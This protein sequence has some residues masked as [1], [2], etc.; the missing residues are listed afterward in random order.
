[1]FGVTCLLAVPAFPLSSPRL[2]ATWLHLQ[3]LLCSAPGWK[4]LG[5][6]DCSERQWRLI[7]EELGPVFRICL[8]LFPWDSLFCRCL[9]SAWGPNYLAIPPSLASPGTAPGS[10]P[11][12][13]WVLLPSASFVHLACPTLVPALLPP[14][15]PSF[16]NL[17]K[18][19][20]N[21]LLHLH[22]GSHREGGVSM[23][24]GRGTE[25][26][27]PG[28]KRPWLLSSAMNQSSGAGP[29]FGKIRFLNLKNQGST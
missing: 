25:V 13:R 10:C 22:M 9:S 11:S 7:P 3:A 23:R 19:F 29:V 6:T 18:P 4:E 2:A 14:W 1:M 5:K 16:P 17:W 8:L 26:K 24:K 15:F 27:W 21:L 20:C 28:F 12:V